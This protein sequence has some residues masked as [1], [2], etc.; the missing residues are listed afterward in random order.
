MSP[1]FLAFELRPQIQEI[2]DLY[3]YTDKIGVEVQELTANGWPRVR[4]VRRTCRR[5]PEFSQA[6]VV[7]ALNRM[8]AYSDNGFIPPIDWTKGHIDPIKHPEARGDEECAKN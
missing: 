3:K 6:E 1:Q 7:N 2:Q 5:G 4:A 8:T